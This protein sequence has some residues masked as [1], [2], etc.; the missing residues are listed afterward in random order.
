MGELNPAQEMADAAIAMAEETAFLY[1][2]SH[3]RIVKGWALAQIGKGNEGVDQIREAI[4]VFSAT[5]ARVWLTLGLVTLAEA[6]GRTGRLQEGLSKVAEALDCVR[7]SGECCWEAE[8]HRLRG[9]L[10]LKQRPSEP[11]EAQ[12]CLYRA[13]EI[14]R[15]QGAKSLEL[16][17]TLS[18][19]R[20]LKETGR[21]DEARTALAESTAGSPKG[22]TCPI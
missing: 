11:A 3:A 21:G 1:V 16:R 10:L 12:A 6:C 5:R 4:A 15:Q 9:E 2:L 19:A 18:L 13:I 22:S 7:Q 8:I 14:S 17:A 20:L